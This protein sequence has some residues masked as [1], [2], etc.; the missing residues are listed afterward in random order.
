MST[1]AS[2]IVR[3]FVCAMNAFISEPIL[4][5]LMVAIIGDLCINQVIMETDIY[6]TT[7]TNDQLIYTPNTSII[8]SLCHI[9]SLF[10]QLVTHATHHAPLETVA[11]PLWIPETQASEL[12]LRS[13][14]DLSFT[15]LHQCANDLVHLQDASKDEVVW[16]LR[17]YLEELAIRFVWLEEHME[18][19]ASLGFESTMNWGAWF[20]WTWSQFLV[21]YYP[22][23]VRNS[24]KTRD[25]SIAQLL[26]HYS[27]K[28]SHALSTY[29]ASMDT[30]VPY[31]P[32]M[33]AFDID[34]SSTRSSFELADSISNMAMGSSTAPGP[35]SRESIG[36]WWPTISVEDGQV[37]LILYDDKGVEVRRKAVTWAGLT[38]NGA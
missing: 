20:G 4:R 33:P 31:D 22:Q 37:F 6:T 17:E 35:L 18:H 36:Q 29:I 8:I 5:R 23:V 16:E 27:S 10:I 2:N 11:C 12:G 19:S 3:A 21:T 1:E 38:K 26:T 24:A 9:T 15:E 30:I 7:S 14:E 13:E 34:L 28:D 25:L 32:N